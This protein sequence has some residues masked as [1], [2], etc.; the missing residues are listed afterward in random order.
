MFLLPFYAVFFYVFQ[1]FINNSLHLVNQSV[2]TNRNI[3]SSVSSSM[4]ENVTTTIIKLNKRTGIE[5]R[6]ALVGSN[7]SPY[8]DSKLFLVSLV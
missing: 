4:S 1:P 5:Q 6:A 7:A 2:K 3:S 8:Q